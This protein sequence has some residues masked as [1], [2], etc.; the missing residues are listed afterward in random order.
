MAFSLGSVLSAAPGVIGAATD[1]M[2]LVRKRKGL[3]PSPETDRSNE[4][5]ALIEKQAEVIEDLA[6]NNRDLALA[7]RVN[8]RLTA[9]S[10]L[11]AIAALAVALL[12]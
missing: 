6:Q 9:L 7:V 8:R 2:E 5:S 10:L 12:G 1:I 4:L 3:S 11:L